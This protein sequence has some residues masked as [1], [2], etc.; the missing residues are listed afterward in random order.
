MSLLKAKRRNV[1]LS[2]LLISFSYHYSDTVRSALV[3]SSIAPHV[4]SIA[5]AQYCSKWQR[6]LCENY[7][8][9]EF[10]ARQ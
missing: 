6:Y 7:M 3:L 2:N 10:H 8:L 1:R 4:V 5:H 9:R